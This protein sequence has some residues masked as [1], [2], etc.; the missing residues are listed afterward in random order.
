[1]KQACGWSAAADPVHTHLDLHAGVCSVHL[2]VLASRFSPARARRL[3][4]RNII[5]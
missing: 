5:D 1:M 2:H 3:V 4:E